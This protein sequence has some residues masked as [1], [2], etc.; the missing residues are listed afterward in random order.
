[1]HLPRLDVVH[2]TVQVNG[3]LIEPCRELG[4]ERTH[5]GRRDQGV[6]AKQLLEDHVEHSVAGLQRRVE[7][8]SADERSKELFDH[9]GAVT[10]LTQRF[11]GA[12]VGLAKQV[13]GVGSP[14]PDP[15]V[16]QPGLVHKGADRGDRGAEQGAGLTKR[17]SEGSK[18]VADSYQRAGSERS[19]VE[20]SPIELAIEFGVGAE[21]YLEPSVEGEPF[22]DVAANPATDPVAGFKHDD[23]PSGVGQDA[24]RGQSGQSG[25]DDRNLGSVWDVGSGSSHA[26]R[27][28][29]ARPDGSSAFHRV[30]WG[31]EDVVSKPQLIAYVDRLAGDLTGLR[32][33]LNQEL[34]GAFGG[35]HLLP[36]FVPIDGADAGF[37]PADH[38]TVDPRLGDWD[39]VAAL[40]A[41]HD[42]MA[43]LIVNHVSVDSD[44]FRDWQARGDASRWAGM[45]LTREHVFGPDPDAPEIEMVYRPRAGRPF[46]VYEVAGEPVEVW[47]TFTGQQ[48]DLDTDHPT[49]MAY[50]HSVLDRLADGGVTLV[51]LDAVGY[52]VKRAGTSCFMLAET[53]ALIEHLVGEA[54]RRG[55]SLLVEIR[56]H[57]RH[58][59]AMADLVDMV[60]DFALGP[61]T[62]FALYTGEV[63]PLAEWLVERPER[64]LTVLDTHDGIGVVDVAAD[65]QHPGLLDTDQLARLVAGIESASGGTSRRAV[66]APSGPGLY[67]INCTIRDALAG[68][69]EAIVLARLM[70]V[71]APGIPQVYYAGLVNAGNDVARADATG[72]PREINRPF[73]TGDDLTAALDDPVPT[74]LLALLRWRTSE[75][76]LFEGQFSVLPAEPGVLGLRW[77]NDGRVL[78][79]WLDFPTRSFTV[80]LDGESFTQ[81]T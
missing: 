6:A 67:Q 21:Q 28:R 36:F 45:F 78:E 7:L 42:V 16:E 62:L 31:W 48:V 18:P 25:A 9:G 64:C 81:F 49:T 69:R 46:T 19:Q 79:A 61:L 20:R 13:S 65:G 17:I 60:Y 75:A 34:A 44:A 15:V 24:S 11:G 56:G 10:P 47:T 22:D 39:G 26:H 55:M 27:L 32:R 54:H 4:R 29:G 71:L 58:Q 63:G 52:S 8:D 77:E 51:R 30:G 66:T 73:L 2:G 37:D 43:D 14:E 35:V 70:Q 38:L 80:T 3:A 41:S 40:A 33:I 68:D 1:M 50:L 59:Q 76:R 23:L 12:G 57:H 5:A 74:D 72:S 53:E